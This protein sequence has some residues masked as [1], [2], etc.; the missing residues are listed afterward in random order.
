[1]T[2]RQPTQA[3]G[4]GRKGRPDGVS[5]AP[6]KRGGK[7]ESDG[8]AYPNPHTGEADPDFDGGQSEKAYHGGANPN[9]TTDD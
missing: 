6:A 8:G 7:G 9:A 4:G 1:M 3:D 2:A 5:D